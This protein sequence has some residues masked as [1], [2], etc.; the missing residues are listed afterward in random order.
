MCFA[1]NVNDLFSNFETV[2]EETIFKYH[3]RFMSAYDNVVIH[4]GQHCLFFERVIE[5]NMKEAKED[6]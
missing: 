6:E 3:K 5:M 2:G 4:G 1:K